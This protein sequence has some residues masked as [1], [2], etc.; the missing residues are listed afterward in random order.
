MFFVHVHVN[1]HVRV[2]GISRV[3]SFQ[4]ARVDECVLVRIMGTLKSD[5]D[6]AH[7]HDKKRRAM[8]SAFC[9][10]IKLIMEP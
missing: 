1:V 10:A 9:N 3:R 4:R 5:Y 6:Y 8:A 2:H 7:E